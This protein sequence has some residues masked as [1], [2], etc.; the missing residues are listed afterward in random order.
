MPRLSAQLALA[1]FLSGRLEGLSRP[2]RCARLGQILVLELARQ[3][4]DE[5]RLLP[6]LDFQFGDTRLQF[7][8]AMLVVS[9]LMRRQ[10]EK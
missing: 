4:E 8:A 3:I 5:A 7:A 10:F 2:G 6:D 1:G 9:A